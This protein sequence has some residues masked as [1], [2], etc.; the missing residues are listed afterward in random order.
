MVNTSKELKDIST[1]FENADAEK[2]S[3]GSAVGAVGAGA[4]M[5]TTRY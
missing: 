2:V 1:R 4:M 5:K 3:L